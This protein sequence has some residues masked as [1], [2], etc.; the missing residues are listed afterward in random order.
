MK[1][2][3]IYKILAIIGLT[4]CVGFA[5]MGLSA[6][7]LQFDST[8]KLQIANSKTLA[9]V[10]IRDIDEFLLKGDTKEV[11][12]YVEQVKEKKFAE[13]LLLYN[14]DG[15]AKGASAAR[16]QK[17]AEETLRSG[18][19]SESRETID[20]KRL[21]NLVIPLKNEERCKGCH[22]GDP[23]NLGVLVLSTSLDKGYQSA[24]K[25][26]GVLTVAGA[27]AF[28]SM[29]TG[30]YFFFRRTIVR[31]IIG[32]S[33]NVRELAQGEGDLT[34]EVRVRSEDEVGHLAQDINQL[35]SKLREIIGG[36]YIEA[37]KVAVKVCQLSQTTAK[38]VGSAATQKDESMTV[39]VAAEEM[40]ATL[41][42][43]AANTHQAANL[44]GEVNQAALEGM[45]SVEESWRCME[46]IKASVE[47]TLESVK[48]L[49]DSSATIGEI[50]SLI[51]EIAD[52]T[53]LLALNAAIEAARAGEHGRGFAVVADEVKNLSSKTAAS[54]KEIA[55]IIAV[56]QEEGKAAS[57]SMESEQVQVIEGV[58]TAEKAKEALE[59]I[60]RLTGECTDMIGQ[61]ATAT[62]EQSATTN[63]IT[64]KIQRISTVAQE[65][66]D[67]MT[68]N[69]D[70]LHELAGV[71]EK[72]YATVGRF[73]VG[74]YH[75]AMKGYACELRDRVESTL[76]KCLSEGKISTEALFSR[77]YREVPNSS[78]KKFTT[79]FDSL[80]DQLI[81]SIQEDVLGKNSDMV[82][83]ICV[84]D[85][86]YCPCHNLKFSKPLT[87]DPAIDMANN[88]T[89]RIFAD[90]TGLKAAKNTDTFLLQTYMRDTGEIMNDLSTPIRIA[91]RHWGGIRIGYKVTDI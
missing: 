58:A 70:S 53:N 91:G 76:Q 38:S 52:Q 54:T 35:T 9:G 51:E 79:Q 46:G 71:V 61:I 83:A 64:H 18:K 1:T 27:I 63:E 16:F 31:D 33:E 50:V 5:A 25:L 77:Q 74:N 19:E 89:K 42:G 3:L 21:L 72:I 22:P 29:L 47:H 14:K 40:A 15:K 7:W 43:V 66:N 17:I 81:S 90:K 56:I 12:R 10:I 39:A 20:G 45:S 78:P 55:R 84:D 65:V 68:V 11:D 44:A 75:D 24:I 49:A 41:N 28:V 62:E 4:L 34:C 88:R 36:L 80:F 69:D 37:G 57:V 32:Y 30:L 23:A 73:R 2:R 26:S 13:D 48:R 82:F 85:N 86:G 67:L 87:G 59:R 8:M 60:S 6:L